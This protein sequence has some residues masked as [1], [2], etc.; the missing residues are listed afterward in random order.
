MSASNRCAAC[1]CLRR[2]CPEDCVLAPYFPS[3]K[4][5]R[6][7]CVHRIYG[8]SNASKMLQQVPVHLRAQA[9]DSMSIEA[10]LRIQDPVYGCVRI[11]SQLQHEIYMTQ[12]ELAKTQAEMALYDVRRTEPARVQDE[13]N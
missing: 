5:Q 9:A 12:Y 6:F 4:P 13:G 11:I 2:R 10:H 1:K 8:A 7:A 3:T